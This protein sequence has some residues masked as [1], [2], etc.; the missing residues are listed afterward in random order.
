MITLPDGLQ[1]K[2]LQEGTGA[3]PTMSNSVRVNYSGKLVNGTEFDSTYNDPRARG[4]ATLDMRGVVKGW[5]EALMLMKEGGKL[6]AFIP[7]DLGYGP[8]GRRGIPPNSALIFEIDLLSVTNQPAPVALPAPAV[9]S[10]PPG[11]RVIGGPA[12]T[13]P[14]AGA[15]AVSPIL[16][17]N[18]DG[19]SRILPPDATAPAPP[20]P[21]VPAKP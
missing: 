15:R 9:S 4:P 3:T 18:P 8:K 16:Q 20:A 7:S 10:P 13:L 19:T 11:A 12:G 21:P 17:V 6:Q 5:A 2:V 14:P 1:Y